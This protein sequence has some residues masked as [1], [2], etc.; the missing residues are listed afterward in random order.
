MFP[1]VPLRL[2]LLLV[3]LPG[4]LGL[5]TACDKE[6]DKDI[7]LPE[8]IAVYRGDGVWDSSAVAIYKCLQ[9]ADRDVEFV[10]PLTFQSDLSD[11]GVVIIGAGDPEAI[12]I[13]LGF[14]GR[15]RIKDLVEVGG[16]YIGL[17][18][19][20]YLA[21]DSMVIRGQTSFQ[22]GI[23][24]FNGLAK[25]PIDL[26]APLPS[27]AMAQVERSMTYLNPELVQNV[28]VLYYGGPQLTIFS[29]TAI[30]IASFTATQSTA[31]AMFEHG[32]GRVVVSSVQ[33]EI[34]EGSTRDGASTDP[35]QPEFGSELAEPE[36]EW[37]WLQTMVEWVLKE[38]ME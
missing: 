7:L 35:Q 29:P 12:S 37:R 16:G 2:I 32:F 15:Q 11:Y 30:S 34:E 21:S 22:H 28:Q 25:G 33:P 14:P 3:C 1:N 20:A 5:V 23:A 10:E 27:Y 24:F 36:S 19:G 26:I 18:A 6:D 38:R 13:A 8:T 31:A 4:V 17:G 9:E